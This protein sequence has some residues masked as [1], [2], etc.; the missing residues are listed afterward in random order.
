MR[1][2]VQLQA[3]ARALSYTETM[4]HVALLLLVGCVRVDADTAT[5]GS[6]PSFEVGARDL[7]FPAK[8]LPG[9]GMATTINPGMNSFREIYAVDASYAEVEARYRR[10]FGEPVESRFVLPGGTKEFPQALRYF[11]VEDTRPVRIIVGCDGC[12]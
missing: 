2:H 12:Y 7:G 1:R 10:C 5:A 11:E 4:R 8:A 3:H 9:E 6:C